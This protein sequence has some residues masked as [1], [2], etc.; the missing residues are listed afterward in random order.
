MLD[1]EKI[2]TQ[3]VPTWIPEGYELEE[4]KIEETPIQK[5]ILAI[6][7]F[8]DST[9]KFQIKYFLSGDPQQ[10]EQSDDTIDIYESNGIT[11][12]I[13]GNYDQLKTVWV[14]DCYECYISGP[15]SMEEI[16]L[17]IDSIMRN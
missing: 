6:Y 7:K 12:Y 17:M 13:L 5:K 9:L 4:I 14:I 3:L 2:T 16:K 1:L 10:I 8:G 11:Y 15:L